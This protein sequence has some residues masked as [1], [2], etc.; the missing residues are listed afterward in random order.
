M[1]WLPMARWQAFGPYFDIPNLLANQTG[2][3]HGIT[4]FSFQYIM[5]KIMELAVSC[6]ILCLMV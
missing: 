2:Q 4:V 3:F 5:K 6:M 1:G